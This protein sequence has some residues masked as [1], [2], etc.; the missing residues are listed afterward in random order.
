MTKSCL[1]PR[2]RWI[3][4]FVFVLALSGATSAADQTKKIYQLPAGDAAATL[5][6]FLPPDTCHVAQQPA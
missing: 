5:K 4:A 6:R 1:F 3:A 2:S